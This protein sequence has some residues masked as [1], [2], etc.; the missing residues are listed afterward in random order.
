VYPAI[1]LVYPTIDL[2]Y[3]C[4]GLVYPGNGKADAKGGGPMGADDGEEDG[5]VASTP[6]SIL[7]EVI[8]TRV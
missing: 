7:S 8:H 4:I 6:I 5:E 1:G 3:P 2:V